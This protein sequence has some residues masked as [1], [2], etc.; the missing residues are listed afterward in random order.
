MRDYEIVYIFDA[1]LDKAAVD[2][3]LE[4]FHG[5]LDGDV[6]TLDHWGTRQLT[7]PIRKTTVGYYVVAHVTA[8]PTKLPE[9]ERLLKLDEQTY[10]YLV[11]L[12]EGQPTSGSSI[13]AERPPQPPSMRPATTAP[14]RVIETVLW[15]VDAAM[16]MI[17]S[18]RGVFRVSPSIVNRQ[19]A[20]IGP[21]F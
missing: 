2:A 16:R 18:L 8:D 4:T 5:K 15:N 9:F 3:K 17:V 19:T 7:Y 10:R 14:V 1:G 13:L 6:T 21:Q 12:N 11:V 20:M